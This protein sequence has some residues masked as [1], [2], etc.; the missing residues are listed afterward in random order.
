MGQKKKHRKS[1]QKIKEKNIVKQ[2]LER[3]DID[4]DPSAY[5]VYNNLEFTY[6]CLSFDVIRDAQGDSPERVQKFPIS[7]YMVAGAQTPPE[8]SNNFL[9]VSKI[10]NIQP[11][12]Q[13]D[14]EDSEDEDKNDE[15]DDDDP[16]NLPRLS[17]IKVSVKGCVN[18]IRTTKI[19]GKT[20]SATWTDKGKVHI[21]DLTQPV[22]AVSDLK[23]IQTYIA[24]KIENKPIFT[25][26][27]HLTEGYSVDWSSVK[28]ANLATGDCKKNIHVWT[29]KSQNDWQVDQQP[30]VGHESSVEDIK[31]SP[32]EPDILSSCSVDRSVRLWDLRNPPISRCISAIENS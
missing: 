2:K 31:W 29:L 18:R 27:G 30:L 7:F 14:E 9:Y 16:K 23:L 13:E 22:H 5:I 12:E 6:P 17:T 24:Q 8:V 26:G 21:H 20:F 25:F 15:E 32:T 3:S 28:T 19:N 10:D 1:S 4:F 11:L